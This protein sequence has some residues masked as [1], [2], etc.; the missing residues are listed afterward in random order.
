SDLILQEERQTIP[1]FSIYVLNARQSYETEN[2]DG[3]IL[4]SVCIAADLDGGAVG[5][6]QISLAQRQAIAL[7]EADE[8]NDCPLHQ[9]RVGRMRSGLVWLRR[10]IDHYQVLRTDGGSIV[11]HRHS[12][13]Y[14]VL[15]Y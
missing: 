4:V 14:R 13:Q 2:G 1:T 3:H 10:M 8:L 6:A 12:A 5:Q 15:W 11:R 9:T 7:G